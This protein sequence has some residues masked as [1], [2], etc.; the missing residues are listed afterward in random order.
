[1]TSHTD[2]VIDFYHRRLSGR[3]PRKGE[4]M[5][6][7]LWERH[8]SDYQ[9]AAEHLVRKVADRGNVTAGSV[10]LSAGH[11]SGA[12]CELISKVYHPLQ[13]TGIDLYAPHISHARAYNTRENV[14]YLTG[15]VVAVNTI[16]HLKG[17][18]THA[19]AIEGIAHFDT[20]EEYYKNVRDVLTRNGR[21]ASGDIIQK[22]PPKTKFEKWL[23]KN[24]AWHW[25]MPEANVI[26]KELY[27]LMLRH[28]GYKFID[29][30]PV[31]DKVFR[32]YCENAMRLENR[33]R[34]IRERGIIDGIASIILDWTISKLAGDGLLE[35][36]I[37]SAKK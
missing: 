12:E 36:V 18:F 30:D 15:D 2:R 7:G 11:G 24:A 19:L 35:Y 5:N 32:P 23:V 17:H 9:S 14:S 37:V 16:W 1:M 4:F 13:I 31:G 26:G 22:R 3:S 8:T 33:V 6:F 28:N 27:Y 21:V 29:I 10:V 20:R 34:Q 25:R